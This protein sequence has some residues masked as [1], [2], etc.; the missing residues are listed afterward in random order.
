MTKRKNWGEIINWWEWNC[1]LP[2]HYSSNSF[3]WHRFFSKLFIGSNEKSIFYILNT[4]MI[5]FHLFWKQFHMLYICLQSRAICLGHINKQTKL[6]FVID[7]NKRKRNMFFFFIWTLMIEKGI[8]IWSSILPSVFF[9]Y[10]MCIFENKKRIFLHLVTV[11]KMMTMNFLA[12]W[13]ND[14]SVYFAV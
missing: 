14:K 5:D 6:Q 3:L 10:P 12:V 13:Y 4:Y 8:R 7:T 11:F 9:K 1:A 2:H